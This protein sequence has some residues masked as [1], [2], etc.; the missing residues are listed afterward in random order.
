MSYMKEKSHMGIFMK[1]VCVAS[2]GIIVAC[3]ITP[4]MAFAHS[5]SSVPG[6]L[7]VNC[8]FET[9]DFTGWDVAWPPTVDEFTFVGNVPHT[10]TFDAELGAVPGENSVSQTIQGT[11]L[12]NFYEV[13][14][15]LSNDEAFPNEFHVQWNGQQIFALNNALGF[16]YTRFSFVVIANGFNDTLR[17]DEQNPPAFFHLDDIVVK[18]LDSSASAP[19]KKPP[20]QAPTKK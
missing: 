2:I 15:W 10:G 8:G 13:S 20:K 5:C 19:I 3:A 7:V 9:G 18:G 4:A 1:K 11:M 14:F 17:F 12:G 16:C 6:N